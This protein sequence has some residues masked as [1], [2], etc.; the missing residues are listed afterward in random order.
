MY[1][2][3]DRLYQ[4]FYKLLLRFHINFLAEFH[5]LT[6]ETVIRHNEGGKMRLPKTD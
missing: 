5:H 4:L 2:I 3:H 6:L 1:L